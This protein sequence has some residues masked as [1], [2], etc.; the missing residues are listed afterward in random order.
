[1]YMYMYAS[2]RARCSASRRAAT[3]PCSRRLSSSRR[4][5]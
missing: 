1:M 2:L 3:E 5:E 4:A